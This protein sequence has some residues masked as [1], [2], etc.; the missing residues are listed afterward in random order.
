MKKF[1]P[2]FGLFLLFATQANAPSCGSGQYF[3]AGAACGE[4]A[5][6]GLGDRCVSCPTGCQ[7]CSP[8]RY[9]TTCQ[10]WDKAKQEVIHSYTYD[11]TASCDACEA[12]YE[13]KKYSMSSYDGNTSQSFTGYKCERKTTAS[14]TCP[15]NC[16]ACSSSSTCTSCKSGY[17]LQNGRCVVKPA[18]PANCAECDDSGACLKCDGGYVLKNGACAV[19]PKTQVAFCPPDKTL[20]ADL[21]CCISK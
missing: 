6:F 14:A 3:E 8:I 11:T 17:V 2:I 18:C 15:A 10:Y 1:L 12:G 5:D 4:N 20:S 21:C 19:K 7:S 16:S 13:L 9:W